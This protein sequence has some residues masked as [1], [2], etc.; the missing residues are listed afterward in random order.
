M[1]RGDR[2]AVGQS[3]SGSPDPL[4]YGVTLRLFHAAALAMLLLFSAQA[5][6]GATPLRLVVL[7]DSLSAGYQLPADAAFPAVLE[8]ALRRAGR[9]VTVVNAGVSGDTAT[10]G[11]ERLDW[12]IGDEAD[13]IIIAL[14]ANDMLR[15]IDPAATEK[16]LDQILTRV[17]ERG[18]RPLLAG[19][20]ASPG[21]G[22]DYEKRFQA[23]FPRLAERHD[24]PLYPFFL[25]GVAQNP[26]LNQQDGIHPN[27][28]GVNEM[29]RRILPAVEKLLD[30]VERR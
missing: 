23:I 7:G 26:A 20:L 29:V 30:S 22:A 15:G 11:L 12:A 3:E 10:A 2:A 27:R 1:G 28:A 5:P 13:A 14:G 25:D 9:D 4:T 19:M 6:A 16:A 17:K 24:A 21:M 8:T 18:I